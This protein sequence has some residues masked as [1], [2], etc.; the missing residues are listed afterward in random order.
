MASF[1]SIPHER[2]ITLVAHSLSDGPVLSLL[3]GFFQQDI[4]KDMAS[5]S[6]GDSLERMIADLNPML[7]GWFGYF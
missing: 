7:R 4:M 6:R 3:E 5:R 1:D 2:L